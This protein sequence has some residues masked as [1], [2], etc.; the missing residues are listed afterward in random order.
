MEA[1]SHR[2]TCFSRNRLRTG[3]A[4]PLLLAAL[5]ACGTP[6]AG[7]ATS[8]AVRTGGE[9][10]GI[11]I[12]VN[13]PRAGFLS[14]VIEDREGNRVRNLVSGRWVDAG[15]REFAWDGYASGGVA[16]ERRNGM[17]FRYDVVFRRVEPGEYTV[18]ALLRDSL[19][20]TLAGSIYTN[21]TIP[22]HLP[23][24][25]GA[26]LSDHAPPVA[27]V[28]LEPGTPYTGA[29][30]AISAELS[31]AGH[32]YA[33]L[34]GR[35][36]KLFGLREGWHG[37]VAL[38][39]PS[40][41]VDRRHLYS[42]VQTPDR[43]V[44]RGHVGKDR[45]QRLYDEPG[46]LAADRALPDVTILGDLAVVSVPSTSELLVLRLG[47]NARQ[48]RLLSRVP[49]DRP[50]GLTVD[51]RGSLW[52]LA[53]PNLESY[54]VDRRTGTLTRTGTV[55]HGLGRPQRVVFRSGGFFVSD[56]STHTVVRLSP[57]GAHGTIF[58]IPGGLRSGPYDPSRMD[59][60]AGL[61]WVGD[62]LWVA[63]N[64]PVLRRISVWSPDG[65]F[66]RAMYGSPK[67]GG[68]GVVDPAD[69]AL[70]YYAHLEDKRQTRSGIAFRLPLDGGPSRPEFVY[71]HPT[72]TGDG[73]SFP[74]AGPEQ[75]VLHLGHR[76]LLNAFNRTPEG[77]TA[78]AGIWM[79]DED[80][81]ARLVAA[82]GFVGAKAGQTWPAV[83]RILARDGGTRLYAWSDLDRDGRVS[84]AEIAFR[85][86]KSEPLTISVGQDLAT[87][88][89][90]FS[91]LGPPAI[92]ADGVPVFDL[93][94]LETTGPG[95]RPGAGDVLDA[96]D[97]WTVRAGGPIVGVH[98]SG[99]TWH[100]DN[101]WY[102]RGQE[103]GL[104]AGGRLAQTSRIV[105]FPIPSAAGP[106]W[107]ANNDLGG[108]YLF[109]ADGFFVAELGGDHR[110]LPLLGAGNNRST[111][112]EAGGFSFDW[113]TFWPTVSWAPADSTAYL[114]AG[115][116]HASIWKIAGLDRFVRLETSTILVTKSQLDGLPDER[117]ERS[118]DAVVPR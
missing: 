16:N 3:R 40:D 67:Y 80:H 17:G 9:P 56:E 65:R 33:W 117:V 13:V 118:D 61:A 113:E 71:L 39:V 49:V 77:Q 32:S 98:T 24:A 29:R 78:T 112:R 25:S 59:Y 38:A 41:A 104:S 66:V 45:L 85:S 46:T 19:D 107:A 43:W 101:P 72:D 6:G 60:P 70:V 7:P 97:G 30:A 31:E 35:G 88:F 57:D 76:Y 91:R 83:E 22:W 109:T 108:L 102:R 92:R 75:P 26:W 1:L 23:D 54:A 84:A 86:V 8:E 51:D 89:S 58:G 103:S 44:L 21:A 37:G 62:E 96:G 47:G 99:R 68:G 110:A 10:P 42:L 20:L 28:S 82:V 52:V 5:A 111:R 55:R 63:E 74:S 36:T 79:L 18:R 87:I 64:S 69:P 105:G 114:Q 73:L 106:L 90:D 100:Y 50:S 94:R 11:R 2:F 95:R 115:K 4:L 34:D 27:I 93:D 15:P 12:L 53:G 14:V 116:E 81:V 48:T